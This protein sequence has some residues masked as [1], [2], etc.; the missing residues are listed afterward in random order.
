MRMKKNIFK[1][2]KLFTLIY[3]IMVLLI[4]DLQFKKNAQ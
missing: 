1:T 3:F 2:T 4:N